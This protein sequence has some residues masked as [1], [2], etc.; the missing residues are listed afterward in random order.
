M[1]TRGAAF[2]ELDPG[3]V[4]LYYPRRGRVR[5]L[6]TFDVRLANY[7][8]KAPGEWE[9][10]ARDPKTKRGKMVVR[11]KVGLPEHFGLTWHLKELYLDYARHLPDWSALYLMQPP[12]QPA[13]FGF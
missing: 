5:P 11:V 10:L 9:Y 6:L 4:A 1:M 13:V 8:A 2:R 12:K 3:L 7:W